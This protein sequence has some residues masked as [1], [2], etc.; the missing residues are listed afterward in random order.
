MKT[1]QKLGISFW[2]YLGHRL[3]LPDAIPVQPLA[4]ILRLS[5]CARPQSPDRPGFCS[6]Y[7]LDF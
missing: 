7:V 1:C 5:D 6:G 4:E 2:G 3:G